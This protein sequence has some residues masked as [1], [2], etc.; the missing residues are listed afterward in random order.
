MDFSL[1]EE[2]QMFRDLFREF[3]QNEVA[4]LADRLDR[5]ERPPTETLAKA[6]EMELLGLPFPPQYGGAGLDTL[7]YCFLMEE[8]GKVCLSTA[9]TIG[10]HTA[11]GCMALY[12][13]GNEEQKER[14]LT[15]AAKGEKIVAFA[16]S[17]PDSGADMTSVRTTAMGEGD[18]YIL[19]GAKG[20]V[21]NGDM[22]DLFVVFA[23]TGDGEEPDGLSA[24]VVE[25]GLPGLEVGPPL[26]TMGVRGLSKGNVYLDECQVPKDCLLGG[27]EGAALETV[28][29]TFDFS[30]LSMAATCLGVAQSALEAAVEFASTR[31]QFGA[32]IAHKGAIQAYVAEMATEV[33]ALRHFVYYTA[34]TVDQGKP[35]SRLAAM[36]KL[37]ASEAASRVVNKAVQ[38]HGGSGYVKDYPMERVYRDT[39]ITR[40]MPG[41]N[42]LQKFLI[43][44]DIFGEKG[45]TLSP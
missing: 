36:C 7:S 27:K 41:L 11:A 35:Y 17:E 10:F 28:R 34:W 18:Q 8:L 29:K 19:A 15:P 12:L 39:R 25:K 30:R 14:F 21:I 45:L 33:E 43:A 32:P 20:W 26:K 6:A 9:A 1:T 23:R 22:A 44:A 3:A 4:P 13:G 38:I 31:V 2:Q 16:L 24:F 37:Q 42:E 5:E 40:I